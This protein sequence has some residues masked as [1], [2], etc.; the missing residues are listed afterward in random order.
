LTKVEKSIEIKA[1]TE[2][3]WPFITW[4]RIPEWFEMWKKV[5]YTSKDKNKVGA[6]VHV[7][8]E[9]AGTKSEFDAEITEFAQNGDG[10]RAWKSI[11]G[12][13]T[14]RGSIALSSQKDATK[15]TFLADYELPYS[16]LGKIIDELRV[17]KAF[18]K[19]FEASAKNLKAAAEK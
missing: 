6:T 12:D 4:E 18:E 13:I 1:P 9:V 7:V 14:A 16:I 3:I 5:E 10:A 17:H 2:K 11:G 8:G 19:S 15:V